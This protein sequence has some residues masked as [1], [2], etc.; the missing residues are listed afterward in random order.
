MNVQFKSISWVRVCVS[1]TE[2]SVLHTVFSIIMHVHQSEI[3]T[4][5]VEAPTIER[6]MK[7]NQRAVSLIPFPP[8]PSPPPLSRADWKPFRSTAPIKRPVHKT[9]FP[10]QRQGQFSHASLLISLLSV[11]W[12]AHQ[13]RQPGNGSL[14]RK[15]T[16]CRNPILH[17]MEA[18]G[19]RV[20]WQEHA[21]Y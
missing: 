15:T 4:I 21:C 9:H 1:L 11:L 17:H 6:A 10:R 7:S 20:G 13:T 14:C 16:H 8:T 12:P 2:Y 5:I 18:V 19:C 3:P